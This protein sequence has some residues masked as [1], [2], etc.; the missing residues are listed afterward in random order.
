MRKIVFMLLGLMLTSA[1]AFS[2]AKLISGRITDQANLA[3]P[4][5]TVHLKGTKFAVAADADGNF[6]IKAKEGDVLVVSGTGITNKEI[7]VTG[8][9]LVIQVSRRESSL[10]EVVVTALG[11]KRESKALGYSTAT[12]N[13]EALNV[14]KPI[15]AAQGLIG[16]VSGAQVSIINNGVDPQIRVQLRGERHII[17]DNQPLF[18]V[19]GMEVNSDFIITINPEDIDNVSVLKSA[20]AAA[21]YG[22]EATNGVVIITTKR[23]S[24]NGKPVINLT[25]TATRENVAYLPQLQN[26]FGGYGGESG[27][28]FTGTPYAFNAINPYTGFTNAIPFEN[29]SFGPQFTGQ[30]YFL[31]VPNQQGKVFTINYSGQS[32]SPIQQFM[33][34]GYTTQTDLSISGGDAKNSNFI[35]V[36][37]VNVTGT[38]PDDKSQR[39]S[40]RLGGKRTYGIF[41]Y[42]YTANYSYKYS[43]VVGNDMTAGWP[44]YWTLLN[45]PADVPV[46]AFKD[47]QDP[48]S[49][50]NLNNYYNAYYINPYWQVANSRNIAKQDNLQGVITANLKPVDWFNLSY[51]LGAQVSN[52]IYE[53]YRNAAIFSPFAQANYGPPIYGTPF[54]GNI[55]GAL[56]NQT[57]LTKRIQQ[58]IIAS[59]ERKFGEDFSAH[60]L[61]GNTIW[62][63]SENQQ[64]QSVGNSVGVVDGVG[65]VGGVPN[66]QTSGLTLPAV[67]NINFQFGI[68]SVGN[69]VAQTRLIGYYSDL[70]LDYKD[71]L[72]LH[73]NFRRDYS[74]LLAPG[75]NSYNVYGVDASLVLSDLIPSLKQSNMLSYGKIRGAYSHTGQ[76][77]L[78][79]Y[80]TVNTF[81]VSSGYP[82]GGLSSL[83]LAGQYNNP[84]NTPEATN[85]EEVGIDLGFFKN[86]V[87]AGVTYYHDNNYNQLFPVSLT[88]ST[89]Y[90]SANVNAANTISKGWEF[91]TKI[92][93]V[94]S[95]NFSFDLGS[96][97]AIQTT[98]VISLYGSGVNKTLQ[99][100][101][102]N[103]NE[104]IVGMTFPQMYVSDLLRDPSNGKVIVDPVSGLPSLA[105]AFVAA[106]RTTPKYI[107]ALTPTFRYKQLTMQVIADYRGGYVFYNNA[108]AQ[109]DFTGITTHTTE[110]GRQNFIF[111]NSEI[112]VN[113]K[114]E[115]NT[116]VYVGSNY[117]FW[118]TS[119]SVFR[120]AGTSYVENA[121]AWKVRTISLSY[122][123]TKLIAG[124]NILKGAKLTALCNNALMFR[125]KQNNF[126]DPEFNAT[127]DN[128]YGNNT[129]YQLPPSRQFTVIASLNF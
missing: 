116:S 1:F 67:Y 121:A 125:P 81:G 80:S 99:T 3:V 20:S 74:S 71:F 50:G 111:P 11:I 100:G 18:I 42:D 118:G 73:G 76:I 87:T 21:L 38:V 108:E 114:Y 25:Q 88:T 127:N 66:Q 109:L 49:W 58:D 94:R 16:Q 102:N 19:D 103:N 82:Y 77:T 32:K 24:K 4:F 106:G 45:T 101:I 64:T 120:S 55:A 9:A 6:S 93:V 29:Q 46:T 51:R 107:F 83:S 15:N 48:N 70:T 62:D 36:Q 23:G 112:M 61:V 33:V 91:E 17:A 53:G 13:A 22:S 129:F 97:L 119:G 110:S 14:S 128:G 79:P 96:N 41:S 98:T 123:F 84:A 72:F 12:V 2:Q 28:F 86:R 124:Q 104:A 40:V 34:P 65:L 8:G 115:P 37:Y 90:S 27:E 60:L 35:G 59:F 39:A 126:T 117:N 30:P 75:H 68:P 85:E 54:S 57:L 10:T 56:V 44:I 69:Y 78:N 92:G 26:Q 7:P 89:G 63:R 43:N 95:K 113:G 105:N 5:A 122:D 31:G 47:W 52:A